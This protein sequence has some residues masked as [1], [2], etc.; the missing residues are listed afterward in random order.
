MKTILLLIRDDAKL[1]THPMLHAR[2]NHG[3]AFDWWEHFK[4]CATLGVLTTAAI[5]YLACS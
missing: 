3:H 1:L 5:L 2:R 4:T